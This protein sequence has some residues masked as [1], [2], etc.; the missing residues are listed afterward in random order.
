MHAAGNNIP[1][2]FPQVSRDLALRA[3]H[4][5]RVDLQFIGALVLTE[6]RSGYAEGY[7]VGCKTE[8]PA[9]WSSRGLSWLLEKFTSTD[10]WSDRSTDRYPNRYRFAYA[11]G[12][13]SVV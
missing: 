2:T 3:A 10:Q 4:R 13:R 6:P 1:G 5:Q 12:Y 9:N 8:P 11:I 7:A